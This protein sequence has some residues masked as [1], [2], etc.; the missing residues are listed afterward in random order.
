VPADHELNRPD[1]LEAERRARHEAE[2]STVDPAVD[3][4]TGIARAVV[5]EDRRHVADADADRRE[6][7][8]GAVFEA[9][10]ALPLAFR[11]Q[12]R[13]A[14]R[15]D[16]SALGA[17]LVDADHGHA[18]GLEPRERVVPGRRLQLAANDGAVRG[19][20]FPG[21]DGHARGRDCSARPACGSSSMA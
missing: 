11:F 21:V 8:Q 6:E 13:R 19:S 3:R 17:A 12:R 4:P 14:R 2:D 1:P 7:R 9:K 5:V 16:D 15:F 18:S 10:E 20:S